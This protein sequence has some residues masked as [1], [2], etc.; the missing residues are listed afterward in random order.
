MFYGSEKHI[1]SLEEWIFNYVI[2][3]KIDYAFRLS[4]I[5]K[6]IDKKEYIKFKNFLEIFNKIM[7]EEA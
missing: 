2:D 7:C 3:D 5:L 6:K 1:K 4:L